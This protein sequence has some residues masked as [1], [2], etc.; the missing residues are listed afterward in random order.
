MNTLNVADDLKQKVL[1]WFRRDLRIE[2]NTAL[3]HALRAN[4]EVVPLFIFDI[5]ILSEL[6]KDDPRVGFIYDTVVSIK[7]RL[8]EMGSSL[9]I[10]HGDP[11]QL[12]KSMVPVAIYTNR[13]YEPY[14][15]ERDE[16]VKQLLEGQGSGFHTFKDQVVF[17]K[18]EIVKD[19]GS[20]YTI[21]TP[22]MRKW[23]NELANQD[24]NSFSV[25]P[26]YSNLLKC[27]PLPYPSL[28]EIGFESSQIAIPP[29][30][31]DKSIVDNYHNTRDIPAIVGTS[32]LG[33]HFRF[34][35]VSI[36]ELVRVAIKM[37][38]T[39]LNELIWREFFM[40]ILWHFPEVVTN[41]FKPQYNDLPWHNN[42]QHF[43]LW[44]E[45][46]TG[47][48]LVDAGMRE[49]NATG[50]MHNRVRMVTASF[51]CKHLLIDWRWGE[52]YF[53]AKLLDYELA[54]NNGNWQ[55]AAGTGCDAAPYFRV[56]NPTRQQERFDPDFTYI[57]K[58]VAEFNSPSYPQPLV[59]HDEARKRA[60]D[61]YKQHLPSNN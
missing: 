43:K 1:F 3:F 4:P 35:T 6:P 48:P 2:D 19:D 16:L 32:K 55:W 47:Y 26:M 20:P 51:L 5:N 53:A 42:D 27:K 15:I 46:K 40:M 38:E 28:G 23:K 52:A 49:L 54:S 24:T 50:F 41:T 45:G 7:S 29:Q 14:A 39:W 31:L 10:L 11:I 12:I 25:A 22:Y 9:L 37:N 60:I 30:T 18:S 13:D 33:L 61:F 34:G 21:Y 56:F 8:E 36:R 59:N 57:K 44:C 17:E 58:W